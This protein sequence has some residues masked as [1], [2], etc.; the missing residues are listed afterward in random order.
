MGARPTL[1]KM[2]VK[3]FFII[4]L[5]I[6]SGLTA[7]SQDLTGVKSIIQYEDTIIRRISAI[8]TN[9]NVTFW[10]NNRMNGPVIMV[11]ATYYDSLNRRV[12][13]ISGHS[14]VGFSVWTYEFDSAG[15]EI[16]V[17]AYEEPPEDERHQSNPYVH[18]ENFANAQDLEND[19][20]VLKIISSG[21]KH[22]VFERLYDNVGNVLKEILF[23][24]DGDTSQITT[25]WYDQNGNRVR[26]HFKGHL[27]EWNYYFTFDANGNELT[28]KRVNGRGDT[29]E[30][31][32]HKYDNNNNLIENQYLNKGEIQYTMKYFYQNELRIKRET[33]N[34][35]NKLVRVQTFEYDEKGNIIKENHHNIEDK[36]KVEY[37][38]KYER[39]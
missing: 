3:R 12:K 15:N 13:S 31:F 34:S 2:T 28:S 38:W 29:T 33:F 19:T 17:F 21:K 18:I 39:Q 24:D 26:F 22:I 32:L 1:K 30:V 16:K 7:K 4:G 23:E 37:V 35:R 8:D 14:N 10:K 36:K 27:G 5:F 6:I 11:C 25:N 9:G 20:T